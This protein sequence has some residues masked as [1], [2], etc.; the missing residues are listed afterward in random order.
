[1]IRGNKRDGRK[2]SVCLKC[3]KCGKLT[4]SIW[5]WDMAQFFDRTKEKSERLRQNLGDLRKLADCEDFGKVDGKHYC[6]SCFE[7][8]SEPKQMSMF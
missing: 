8:E 1:M 7:V 2:M 3:D 6:S 5:I 4:Q